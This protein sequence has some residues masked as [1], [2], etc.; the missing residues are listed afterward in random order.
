MKLKNSY[1]LIVIAIFLLIS[2]GSVCA[3]ENITD[4]SDIQ[5]CDDGTDVVLSDTDDNV[6]DE[7]NQ[8]KI[9]TTVVTDKPSYEFKD[10]SNKTITVHVKD[11]KSNIDVDKKDLSVLNGNKN[12]SF[13]YNSSII[14]I[15]EQLPCGYYNLTINYLGNA[16][17]INSSQIVSVK[18]YGNNSIETQTNIVSN[19]R[20]IE[21]PVK[22]KDQVDYIE[23]IKGN[24]N[25]TLIYTN[26]NGNISNLTITEFNI[27]ND[28]IKF[29]STVSLINAKVIID[30]ANSTGA[31]TV[32]IKISTEVKSTQDEYK[33][34]SEE[35]K[36]ISIKIFDGQ[37]NQININ[38]NDL[39]VFDNGAEITGFNYNN[40]NLTLE[41]GEGVHNITVTYKGNA[42][43]NEST[44]NA[45]TVKVSGDN[46]IIVPDYVVSDETTVEIPVTIFDGSE[47]ITATKNFALNLTYINETGDITSKIIGDNYEINNGIIKFNVGNIKLIAASVTVDYVNSTG[48]KT[49][50][51]NLLTNVN[52]NPEKTKYRFN[53]TNNITVKVLDANGNELNIAKTDLKVFD[54]GEEINFEYDNSIMTVALEIGV[55]NLT[56]TY[57]GNNTYN[58]SANTI[59][60]KVNGSIQFNPSS[61]AVLDENNDVTITINLNDGA[62]PVTIDENKLNVTVFY[63]INDETLNKTIQYT[64]N[65]QNITFNMDYDF[66]GAFAEIKYTGITATAETN[67]KVNTEMTLDTTELH[68]GESEVK[69]LTITVKGTNSHNINLT[70]DNIQVLKDGKALT[71]EVNNSVITIK[72]A[73]KYGKY[74]LTVKYLGDGTYLESLKNIT[75]TVYGINATTSTN[76]NSTKKGE[77]N[78]K[79]YDGNNTVDISKDDLKLNVTYNDGNKTIEITVSEKSYENGTL[80]F[81]LENGNFTTA[82]LNIKFN[83]T[84][85]NV[86][87]NRVYNVNLKPVQNT[88][89]YQDGNF[90]FEVIDI[91]APNEK[92]VNK[93]VNLEYTL[94]ISSI[95]ITSDGNTQNGITIKNTISSKT[96]EKGI[97]SF[98]NK[99]MYS[100]PFG[101]YV[102]LDVGNHAVTLS[103]SGLVIKNNTQNLT[104]T[105]AN[106][107]ITLE[108]FDEYYGTDKKVII[109]VTNA[110]S[111]NTLT[112]VYI[113]LDINGATL[114][115]T[116]Q[117][118]NTEG[119]IQLGVTGLPTGTY[120]MNL[121]TNDTNL[122]KFATTGSFTIKKIPVV[123]N[124][125]DVTI[126]YNTGTSYTVKVTEN[127]KPIEG[128]YILA[129]FDKNTKKAVIGTTDKNGK[130]SFTASLDVGKHNIIIASAD[131]RYDGPQITK[132]ITVKKANAKITAKKV[133][134]YYKD[135][136]YLTIKLTNTKNKKPIY[137]AEINIKIFISK[138]RY[139]NYNGR[140]AMDGKIKLLLDQLKP[141]TYKVVV[142]GAN[143]KN[144]KASQVTTKIVL[145]KA[146][147]KITAKKL[148]AKK[149]AKKYFKVTVKNK[150]TKKV[151]SKVKVKIKVF[152]GKKAKTYTVKTNSKGIA[153]IST[154]K[155]KVGKHKVSVTSANKYVI[156]KNT[157]SKITIKK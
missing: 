104:V 140:T 59:E 55:H 142:S 19:G 33:F 64:L 83:G 114:S 48:A 5:S 6:A 24:F 71:I 25:I 58:S 122:N 31:K 42:T 50:K 116:R 150:K 102:Y 51:I 107:K 1:I 28:T 20:D 10:D 85:T 135:G 34:K 37:G 90:T 7:T 69:N 27:D 89:E 65:G 144:F 79:I 117:Q 143:S 15:T 109:K 38:E 23:M 21:I 53:E 56:V 45:I 49:V 36:S 44:S 108:P 105:H 72:D 35:N 132:T 139:Y 147:A 12:I 100:N 81:T 98:E 112:G 115:D 8:E 121:A 136:K 157:T 138:N 148:T 131:T 110:K 99:K 74:N 80:Y 119:E 57:N 146:P 14:T 126:Q 111:G 93:T 153:K 17:Y 29:T 137:D 63:T 68:K 73:L 70:Q 77:V 152:T 118:T 16:T 128:V 106:V 125:K 151:I 54:N 87:L 47:N 75:L 130:I 3:S 129:V 4:D 60:L 41:L 11:N 113:K 123:L 155:L 61:E 76:I 32:D 141:G 156:A 78:V 43:Y 120:Q 84:E 9:N 94:F 13:E 127:G 2:I 18:I 86:T 97:V 96:D 154:A 133:T 134:G 91:D 124:G 39:K 101:A 82:T 22:I 88:N 46:T 149:G 26:E 103:G 95:S 40:A 62:D 66:D 145:K 30:Y 52:I 92:V 67:I